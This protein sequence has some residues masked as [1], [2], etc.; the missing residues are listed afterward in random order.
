[1]FSTIFSIDRW[2]EILDTLWR[3]KLRSALT[4][5]SMAWGIFMLVV[6]LGLGNGLQAGVQQ[7][8]ADDATNSIWLFGGQTSK[9]AQG[10]PVGRR[11]VMNN[12]DVDT[13][14]ALDHVDHI[15]GRFNMRGGNF[16]GGEMVLRVGNKA[17]PFDTRAVHPDHVYLEN[18]IMKAGRFINATDLVQ[19]RKVMVIGIPV[20]EFLF[21]EPNSALGKWIE[22][23]KVP[24][25]VVGLYDDTGNDDEKKK[26]YIPISTAQAAFNGA[27]RVNQIMF[28]VGDA[29]AAESKQIADEA[30][31]QLAD[32]HRFDAT[33]PQAI[34]VRN[35]VENFQKFQQIFNMISF[36][37]L[38]MGACALVAGLVGVSN[39]M[40]IAVRERTREIGIRKALGATP[41]TIVSSI[42]QEAI[43]LT[44]FAGYLGLCAGVGLLALI[45]S[46]VPPN[47]M[48]GAPTISFTYA[49]I[50][51]LVLIITGALAGFFPALQ[52]AKV[53]PIVA[54][55]DE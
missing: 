54:L 25:Q 28:T 26:A 49:I 48:F 12:K 3:N 33:D 9:P 41:F 44:S 11:I 35:N 21:G 17:Q 46:A 42:V 5:L 45:E 15:T 10:L 47:E 14:A 20:A 51:T 1:V 30:L 7:G 52:A 32:V 22:L 24:F 55:R 50:A 23:N 19:R 27:D 29:D 4:A 43:F 2:Q 16:F 6:L 38:L 53:N 13:L 39:I 18:T 31:A 34:R 36:F 8:F 40:M 37:V